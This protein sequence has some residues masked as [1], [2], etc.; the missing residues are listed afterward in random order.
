MVTWI[1]NETEL[2]GYNTDRMS[3]VWLSPA[4]VGDTWALWGEAGTK[5]YRIK[6]YE[7][8]EEALADLETV[9]DV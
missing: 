8:R 4:G 7:S 2:A 3:K 6:E 5:L 9:L 1:Y